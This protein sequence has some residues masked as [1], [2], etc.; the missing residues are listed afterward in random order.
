[1]DNPVTKYEPMQFLSRM[2]DDINRFF[3]SSR[4]PSLFD[5]DGELAL[6]EWRP[7]VDVKETPEAYEFIVDIPGVDP[8]DIEVSLKNGQLCIKGER[9]S[10][11]LKEEENY[12][13]RECEYGSFMRVFSLPDDANEEQIEAKSDRGRVRI[14]VGRQEAERP[15]IIEVQ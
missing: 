15:R 5:D 2:Q 7:S 12:R 10:E 13:H 4:L 3:R 1:M 9:R 11:E 14:V 8:K 6:G